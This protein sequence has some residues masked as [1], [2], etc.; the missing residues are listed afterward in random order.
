M[1][2][3]SLKVWVTSSRDGSRGM[4]YAG[5]VRY[6]EGGGLTAEEQARREQ[7]R[8]EAADLIEAGASDREVARRFRVTRMSA[9]RWRCALASGDRQ[10]SAG[11]GIQG[12]RRGEREGDLEKALV[13]GERALEGERQSVP[14]LIMT[15]RGLAAEMSSSHPP[16]ASGPTRTQRARRVGTVPATLPATLARERPAER[17]C[18]APSGV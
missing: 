7:V 8:F 17:G 13:M 18:G 12:S 2:W 6:S 5:K 16:R 4:P 11:F 14:S 15:S 9:N 10:A 3:R 1:C